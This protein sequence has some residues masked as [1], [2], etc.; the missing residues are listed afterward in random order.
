MEIGCTC[1][2]NN[3]TLRKNTSCNTILGVEK[4]LPLRRLWHSFAEPHGK[5]PWY[6]DN[7]R[8]TCPRWSLVH[9]D[10]IGFSMFAIQRGSWKCF[11]TPQEYAAHIPW[12]ERRDIQHSI[13]TCSLWNQGR[14][15]G[16]HAT[17]R[18]NRCCRPTAVDWPSWAWSTHWQ[19]CRRHWGKGIWLKLCR[20]QFFLLFADSYKLESRIYNIVF[21]YIITTYFLFLILI[22]YCQ[23]I[24]YLHFILL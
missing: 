11:C 1:R 7:S 21:Q 12:K 19:S 18:F 5:W 8:R 13:K 2:R 20:I 10:Q 9:L 22:L 4:L 15:S 3:V 17:N 14:T 16:Q 24:L 23:V 6:F